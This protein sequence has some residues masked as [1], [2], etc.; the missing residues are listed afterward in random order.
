MQ[1]NTFNPPPFSEYDWAAVTD[2]AGRINLQAF[3]NSVFLRL[4][5]NLTNDADYMNT[6]NMLG[7]IDSMFGPLHQKQC[8]S[9]VSAILLRP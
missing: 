9:I 2:D 5:I 1:L 7:A 6:Y 8:I 3:C 4:G